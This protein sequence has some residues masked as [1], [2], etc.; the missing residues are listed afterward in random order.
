VVNF[1]EKSIFADSFLARAALMRILPPC[2]SV[3]SV[4]NF[5]EKSISADSFLDRAAR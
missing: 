1:P 3:S 4:V 5:P 2:N